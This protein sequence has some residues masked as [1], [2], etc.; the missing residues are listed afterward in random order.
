MRAGALVVVDVRRQDAA[1]MALV[2]DHDV[3]QTFAA[4]RADH[5]LDIAVLPRGAWRRNDFSDAHSFDPV[6]EIRAVRRVMVSEQ[7]T[8]SG[9]PRE[10]FG[11]LAQEPSSS[12]MLGYSRAYDVPSIVGQNDH[13][14]EK[15]ERCGRHDKHVNRSDALDL[16]AQKTAPGWEGAPR[17][18]TIYLATV[19]WLTSMPSLSSSPWIRGAPQSG[20]E[21][22]ICRIRARLSR[23]TDGRPD[24]E[25]HR[26]NRRNH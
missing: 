23:S 17:L 18:R 10:C 14:V 12:R 16:I 24:F 9:V 4:N 7:I 6:A 1:Q 13:D 3:I 20:L 22:L 2:E 21:P 15:P 25:R 26:Q 19:A 8:R 5:A 11:Y